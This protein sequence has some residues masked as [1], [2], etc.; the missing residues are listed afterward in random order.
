VRLAAL[1]ALL[2]AIA[3]VSASPTWALGETN[4]ADN[5]RDG[6]YP[7]EPS[8]TPSLLSGG[9]FG[10]LWSTTVDGQVYAQPLLI[11]GTLLVA[12]ENNKVYGLDPATGA[13]RWAS[14]LS[15]GT[16][17]NPSDLSCGDLTPHIGTTSTPVIDPST[18]IAYLTHKTYVSG[19]S[20]PARWYMD[21]VDLASGSEKSG[22]PVELSGS[23]QNHPSMTFEPTH[24]MQ[25]PGLLLLN[26][27]VYAGFGSHC[28]RQPWQGWIFGVSTSGQV[29]AR[30][31]SIPEGYGAGIWQSGSGL[32]SDGPNSL[33]VAT[34]NGG[35]P[36]SATPGK[37]PPANLGESVV[38]LEVQ[39]D[40]S[41]KP[42]DFF[43]PFDAKSLDEHD[44]DFASG[45]V[46]GLNE[47]YFGTP[48]LP[49]LIVEVG[50]DGYVYLLNRE[51]LG[52]FQQG[53]GGA[54]NVVQR[55]GPYGGVWS[56]PGVW[57]GDG[58]WIYIPT[59][60]G[61]P[62]T[63]NG[64]LR[65][66]KYGLSGSG[67]P[68]L[69]LQATSSDLFGF[70][71]SAPVIT[72]DGTNSGS[73]LVWTTWMPEG[74]G[75][76][77][78][79][80]AYDPVPVEGKPVLRWS[81][82]IGT[83]SK[84]AVP[85]VGGG[86]IYVGTR[87]GKVLGFGS[88]VT[89]V[90]SGSTTT[91][92][93]T[94]VG[95]SSQ[96]TLTLTANTSVTVSKL[97][98]SSSQFTVGT[99]KPPLPAELSAGQKLE[100]P[101]TFTPTQSGPV[102]GTLTAETSGGSASFSMS[103]TGQ[104]QKAQ[105]TSSPPV[106][107][108]GGTTVGGHVTGAATFSNAGAEPLTINTVKL[109]VA[110]F[111]ASGVPAVGSTIP[112][113]GSVTVNLSFDPTS[114]G[115]FAGE[116]VLE[117]TGGNSTVGLT[118]SAG[119]AGYLQVTNE[120]N[121][122]G[123]LAVGASATKTF[124][125]TNTGG[126]AVTITK[127]KPPSG[128]AFEPTTTLAEGTTIAPGGSVTES[129]T[130]KPNAP[131]YARAVWSINGEDSSGPHEVTFRGSG[132][133]PGPG[134]AWSHNGSASIT[135]SV[136]QTTPVAQYKAGSSFFTTP[137]D[138]HHLIVEFDE[139]MNGGTGGDGQTLL[140]A[141]ASKATPSS[142]GSMGGALGFSPVSG[143]VV[144]F[145][146]F[147]SSV[148]PSNNFVGISDGPTSAGVDKLHWL[149]TSSSIPNLRTATR[150]VKVELL[151]GA[152]T[153]WMEGVPVLNGTAAVAPTV[154][155]GFTGGTGYV[156]DVHKVENVVIS[157]DPPPASSPASL[158]VAMSVSAP[159][160]ST[161]AGTKLAASGACPSVF[162]TP[163][164]GDGASAT[165][166]LTG[167][168]SGASCSVSEEAPPEPGWRTTATVD[169][170]PE[171][172]LTAVGGK[173]TV[174]TF[175]LGPGPNTVH[176]TNTYTKPTTSIPDPT[177]GGWQLNGRA[178]LSATELSLT[179]TSQYLAG[180]A[181]WPQTID[182]RNRTIEFE[183]FIGEGTGA[184]GLA[185]VI[186]DAT[187]G[188]TA[189]SIGGSGGG[190]GFA[191]IPGWAV[192]LDTYKNSANP[193]NNFAG[194]SDGPGT[195]SSTL[196]WLGTANLAASL[197]NT[198]HHLTVSTANGSLTVWVDGTQVLSVPLTLPSSAYL[199]FSG[200]TGY[201]TDRHAIKHLVVS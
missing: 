82:P 134:T 172:T 153:V 14:P 201:Y 29:K 129:V 121:D 130:F 85:G 39:P 146:T 161:Q 115:K 118:G 65:V 4:A 26:G 40:G 87:D 52:G 95:A 170:G 72:S 110:P 2:A 53:P 125:V 36:T 57:P 31:V 91:F 99:P 128:G 196:H 144:A 137:L 32:F 162:T 58:G 59:A 117:S 98:S 13:T 78:Q 66:Y 12:T 76:G 164:L 90:L 56:R 157:G 27:V 113:G 21:A 114:E 147:K 165:P 102:A 135:G 9:T 50:K 5:L 192:A 63:H 38:R 80:R 48:S 166:A 143:I 168:E 116:L 34:G 154:L 93:S 19:T 132:T 148:N 81:A 194:I 42:V 18:N 178:T 101:L 51:N 156:T 105:L 71:T 188:A 177:A 126:T 88:P 112:P 84:F 74:G 64:Y 20:G 1:L 119:S 103:G 104:S 187:R 173:L 159:G 100:V 185:L 127:S 73:A 124:T 44:A 111:S 138:S 10:Q 11:N 199:G 141:D 139:T 190:L 28:D 94:T 43:A 167:A 136:L 35:S 61:A 97:T 149:A 181:F 69:S 191:G 176:F 33:L 175:T 109:P 8:L 47:Q 122:Y 46:T 184:D 123:S 189:K 92:P 70:G 37:S 179:S 83:G 182:P 30:W 120:V 96:K 140:F 7:D 163:A 79:L 77:A 152:I 186:A 23:A 145:V 183:A 49:R 89:P 41:L 180:S 131:G 198:T 133:V 174:P 68:T 195:A 6:W 54:D 15:L 3:L 107:S 150:H 158:Q 17:W 60:S 16:P 155:L 160:G 197:R 142:L 108:F 24:Q 75:V 25:R 193:S 86:R 200:G 171:I 67:Q 169:G 106:V 22:F 62:G 45:G 151:N 55:I